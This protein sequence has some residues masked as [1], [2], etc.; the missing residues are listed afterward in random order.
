VLSLIRMSCMIKN[1]SKLAIV[2]AAAAALPGVAQA[3]TSTATGTAVIN[4]VSQCAVTGANVSLGS[5]TAGADL[6]S[7]WCGCGSA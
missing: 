4:I 5:Y 1:F 3:G 6:E 7:G 2:A